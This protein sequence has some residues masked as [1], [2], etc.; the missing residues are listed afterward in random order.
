MERRRLL[1]TIDEARAE[2]ASSALTL[3]VHSSCSPQRTKRLLLG[4]G[5][6]TRL[7]HEQKRRV[8]EHKRLVNS[9]RADGLG[10]LVDE[11]LEGVWSYLEA[12]R[13]AEDARPG[14]G[15]DVA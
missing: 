7:A 14:A 9:L 3:A 13:C 6:T 12:E 15:S 2:V 10:W 4:T 5:R 1:L 8:L 11:E